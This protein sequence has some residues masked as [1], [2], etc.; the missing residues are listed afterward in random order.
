MKRLSKTLRGGQA[1]RHRPHKPKDEGS[2][3]SPA[4]FF[5]EIITE[6]IIEQRE[7]ILRAFVAKY[8]LHPDECEQV[9]EQSKDKIVW[10]V[11]KRGD[12]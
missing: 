12:D 4:T 8:K 10:R 9:I 1:A 2:I 3:P 7:E 11:R 6:R 5:Q